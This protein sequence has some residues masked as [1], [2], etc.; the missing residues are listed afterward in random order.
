MK[1]PF[2]AFKRATFNCKHKTIRALKRTH[3][4]IKANN[5]KCMATMRF[6]I[7]N[8]IVQCNRIVLISPF[9]MLGVF[10]LLL[11]LKAPSIRE[12]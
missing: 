11:L 5:N 1:T 4:Q 10:F 12:R 9:Q 7:N 3:S 2:D 8:S 6:V